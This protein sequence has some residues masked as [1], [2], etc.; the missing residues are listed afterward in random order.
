MAPSLIVIG[1]AVKNM[2]YFQY[3][4]LI[5]VPFMARAVSTTLYLLRRRGT[6][7]FFVS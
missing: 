4:N 7:Q 2:L 6:P 5:K 3:V 1:N